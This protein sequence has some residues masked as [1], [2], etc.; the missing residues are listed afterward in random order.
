MLNRDQLHGLFLTLMGCMLVGLVLSLQ[1]LPTTV[2]YSV[3]SAVLGAVAGAAMALG[4][5]RLFKMRER[6]YLREWRKACRRATEMNRSVICLK[7]GLP[8]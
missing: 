6:L 8:L 3:A 1:T 2:V 7:K 4:S 5:W